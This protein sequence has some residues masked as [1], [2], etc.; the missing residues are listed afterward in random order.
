LRTLDAGVLNGQV[1]LEVFVARLHV[2]KVL[3]EHSQTARAT[4][5]TVRVD[6][7]DDVVGTSDVA[8]VFAHALAQVHPPVARSLHQHQLVG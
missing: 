2:H 3:V 5:R 4:S 1:E 6:D 8:E 7:V